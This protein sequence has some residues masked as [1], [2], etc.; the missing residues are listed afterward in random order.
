[1]GVDVASTITNNVCVCVCIFSLGDYLRF[2]LI[3]HGSSSIYFFSSKM[4]LMMGF[5]TSC[6]YG[7]PTAWQQ[8][9]TNNN[10]TMCPSH[11][12]L[13]YRQATIR[14]IAE[15][16]GAR[17]A[18]NTTSYLQSREKCW[19]WI[20][21]PWLTFMNCSIA[22]EASELERNK[23]FGSAGGAEQRRP[24]WRVLEE[25]MT[26]LNNKFFLFLWKTVLDWAHDWCEKMG[27]FSSYLHD[28]SN[29][30]DDHWVKQSLERRVHNRA[31]M[32]QLWSCSKSPGW[33]Y[34]WRR[35]CGV[36]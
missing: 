23:V 29:F 12:H 8:H 25:N 15:R 22:L 24:Y 14:I 13:C 19:G 33:K 32:T 28:V 16:N 1:M 10:N 36:R 11:W 35:D 7:I 2:R 31:K 17:Q 6:R 9:N 20:K 30:F 26:K 4:R 5:R 34:P 21:I 3:L 27:F 18:E